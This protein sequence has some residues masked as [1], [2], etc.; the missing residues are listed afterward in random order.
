MYILYTE[1]VARLNHQA[2]T[3][4]ICRGCTSEVAQTWRLGLSVSGS[5]LAVLCPTHLFVLHSP[6]SLVVPL[7]SSLQLPPSS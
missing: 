3:R 1:R 4:S 2:L 7:A 5:V 6:Y